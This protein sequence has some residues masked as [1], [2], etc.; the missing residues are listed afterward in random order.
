MQQSN[1]FEQYAR[2]L[3]G[4]AASHPLLLIVEDLHWADAGSVSLLFHLGRRLRQAP[5]LM[6][7]TFR[8]VEVSL[9]RGGE[10]HPLEKVFQELKRDFGDFE[11]AVGADEGRRFV[12][13]YLDSEPNELDDS[14][15]DT[16]FHQ[17]DGHP[18]FTIELLRDMQDRGML[19]QDEEGRW[20][21]SEAF[22]WQ[23]LPRKVDAVI[24]ERMG[25]LDE[26]LRSILAVA[27]V[28]G[29][30]F[31][32]E[33]VSRLQGMEPRAL[34]QLLSKEF[35]KKHRLVNAVGMK[36]LNGRRLSTYR[37]QHILFQKYLYDS[38]DEAERSYLHEEMGNTLED[39]HGEHAG[40]A[41]LKL[42]HHFREAGV[43]DKAIKYLADAGR[44]A[45]G[46]SAHT[47][48][49]SLF[50]EALELLGSLPAGEARDAQEFP[51]RVALG[52]ALIPIR[53]YS[54]PDVGEACARIEQLLPVA[55]DP[56]LAYMAR[57][58]LNTY[59]QLRA[60]FRAC[61]A[62]QIQQKELAEMAGSPQLKGINV[63]GHG[64][65][66]LHMG[67]YREALES[68]SGM[69]DIYDPDDA[70]WAPHRVSQDMGSLAYAFSSWALWGLGYP[71]QALAHSR[72]CVE[73]S[74]SINHP[75]SEAF[76]LCVATGGFNYL[77][78]HDVAR[79]KRRI[80]E[81]MKLAE[82]QKFIFYQAWAM[83]FLGWAQTM[84]GQL[85]EGIGAMEK[86][87]G[88]LEMIGINLY[89]ASSFV[90]GLALAYGKAGKTDHALELLEAGLAAGEKSEELYMKSESLR[91]KGELLL[92]KGERGIAERLFREAMEV[93]AGQ[94]ARYL[95]L[96]AAN[97]L[98]TVLADKGEGAEAKEML[99][100][101]YDWF[102]EGFD[103]EALAEARSILSGLG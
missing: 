94:E 39:L 49:V 55:K 32:A 25:R 58:V 51:L 36:R 10:R 20:I 22:D 30:E 74:Q 52:F 71:D 99:Q 101:K 7:G 59:H 70:A 97:S 66:V 54:A 5:V 12:D 100:E 65:T 3:E 33:A 35:E 91:A 38:L 15:R 93:A 88:I 14:F 84:E 86:G 50:N 6:V 34:V 57:T 16:L 23:S 2:L 95:E 44:T 56:Q 45:T 81:M 46:V 26:S 29:E 76:G 79:L 78:A 61:L 72:K 64:N 19:R 4:I 67:K 41:S 43:V 96:R 9:G 40:E 62:I 68:F 83:F 31:T 103:S 1:L 17:T 11:V 73:I 27:A 21:E 90:P 37:F 13:A 47:E 69:I 87:F 75:F 92:H 42:A 18:L 53:G 77:Y 98:A 80:G 63:A 89:R 28:E 85:P 102:T 60:E 82:K 8:P 48:A 24:E